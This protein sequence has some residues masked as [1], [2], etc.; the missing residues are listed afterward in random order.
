MTRHASET[1]GR[2]RTP[3]VEIFETP[4]DVTLRAEMPGVAKEDFDVGIEGDELTIRGKRRSTN[5]GLR[6]IHGGI[7]DTDYY[8]AFT[9][10]DALDTSDVKARLE[11]GILTLTLSKKPEILPRKIEIEVG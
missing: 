8:R 10:G 2:T 3:R 4:R 11:S 5:S 9:L 6:L 1:N 7:D